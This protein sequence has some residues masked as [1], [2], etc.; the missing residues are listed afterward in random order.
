MRT[1][2]EYY[3]AGIDDNESISQ[4]VLA[5]ADSLHAKVVEI[6]R[7]AM[8]KAWNEP[9]CLCGVCEA[10]RALTTDER[11]ELEGD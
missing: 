1:P 11:K 7:A 10:F 8:K 4:D 9:G 5:A 3:D 2:S 6:A